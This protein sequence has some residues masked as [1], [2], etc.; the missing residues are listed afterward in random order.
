MEPAAVHLIVKFFLRVARIDSNG[1]GQVGKLNIESKNK[2]E[3]IS[4]IVCPKFGHPLQCTE[5][6]LSS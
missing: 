6:Y 1:S 4:R 5:I 2:E 3:Q